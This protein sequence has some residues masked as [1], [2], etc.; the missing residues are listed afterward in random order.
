[1]VML[2]SVN[3]GV[4]SGVAHATTSLYP[5]PA[6]DFL[7]LQLP[8]NVSN[9]QIRIYD[10]LGTL[11]IM[12]TK[13]ASFARIAVGDLRPGVY[14]VEVSSPAGVVRERFVKE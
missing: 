4:P 7:T 13:H 11:K 10:L 1:M 3:A 12:D 6:T 5:N 14:V 8:R 9:T 2:P